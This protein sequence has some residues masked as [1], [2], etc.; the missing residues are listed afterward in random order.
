MPTSLAG[1][2]VVSHEKLLPSLFTDATAAT[3]M[4]LIPGA[5]TSG[6]L[7]TTIGI[8][9]SST[10]V[11]A[12]VAW[13]DSPTTKQTLAVASG[14]TSEVDLPSDSGTVLVTTDAPASIYARVRGPN[15][16][17]AL[18]VVSP[19]SEGL[20][21]G[22]SAIPL[23]ADGLEHSIDLTRGRETSLVL[24]EIAGQSATVNVRLYDPGSRIAAIAEKDFTIA[25]SSELRIE[26]LFA[27][28]GLETGADELYQRRKN[29]INVA[30]VVTT[31]TGSGLV[32]AEAILTDNKIGDRRTIQLLPA[33][34]VPATAIQRSFTTTAPPSRRRAVG[35]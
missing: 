8:S 7:K 33:G 35:R 29:Q 28:M 13:R 22:G 23:Y 24:T 21:G 3:Q 12:T 30:A 32:A 15:I 11:N 26:N 25:A 31:T 18:P 19:L 34:G 6:T 17:D 1:V 9:A 14:Q 16:A 5:I 27:A 10:S 4:F 20:T 2:A